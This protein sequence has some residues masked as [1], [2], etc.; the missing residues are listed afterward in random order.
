MIINY[1][2]QVSYAQLCAQIL[3]QTK[4]KAAFQIR[5]LN[6]IEHILEMSDDNRRHIALIK[7]SPRE[8][9]HNSQENTTLIAL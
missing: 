1:R 4:T 3:N 6:T 7:T 9:S 2:A 5:Y 8:D